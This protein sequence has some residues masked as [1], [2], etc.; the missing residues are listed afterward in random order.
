MAHM[1]PPDDHTTPRAIVTTCPRSLLFCVVADIDTASCRPLAI[2]YRQGHGHAP[3][4]GNHAPG[5]RVRHALLDD[6]ARAV[7]ILT[8]PANRTALEAERALALAW[9]RQ[10]TPGR[11]YTAEVDVPDAPQPPFEMQYKGHWSER[12]GKPDRPERPCRPDPC[13]FPFTSTCLRLALTGDDLYHTGYGDV[14]EQP[15]AC[16]FR[17]DKLEYGLVVLDISDLDD[18][19]YGFVAPAVRYTAADIGP[20]WDYVE[21]LP[22]ARPPTPELE[23][24]PSR[25]PMAASGFM[26]RF[27]PHESSLPLARLKQH[28]VVARHALNREKP[29]S[30]PS[31]CP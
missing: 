9:C 21:D 29:L 19:R 18:V 8:H 31:P 17:A 11:A 22:L 5:Q 7:A 27:G 25:T 30:R 4:H 10:G 13:G 1:P 16:V 3:A 14:Q 12:T 15:L 28:R 23:R 2:T 20:V 6:A 26:T 24:S